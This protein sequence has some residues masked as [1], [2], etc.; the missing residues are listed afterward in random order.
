MGTY[1]RILTWP[2]LRIAPETMTFPR[3]L[4]WCSLWCSLM[5]SWSWAFYRDGWSA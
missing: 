4:R 1:A 2:W 5:T 3:H